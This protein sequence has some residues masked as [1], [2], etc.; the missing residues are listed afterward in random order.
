MELFRISLGPIDPAT[1]ERIEVSISDEERDRRVRFEARPPLSEILNLHDFEVR[2]LLAPDRTVSDVYMQ[3]IAR[4]IMPEKAWA[5]YSSA[6]DDEITI[7]E[8]H[9][10]FHRW[11]RPNSQISKTDENAPVNLSTECGF[12]PG[13]YV[14]SRT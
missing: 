2:M 13:F 7:R 11:R 14:M 4:Q 6:A 1:V 9:A 8:N 10:A 5:Y 12:A 3:A